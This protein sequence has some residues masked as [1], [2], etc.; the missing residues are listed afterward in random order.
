MDI[1]DYE[2]IVA[3][4]EQGSISRA[5]A[6][7]FITQSALTRFLQRTERDLGIALFLRKGNQFLLTEAGQQYVE[8]GRVIMHL[9]RELSEKLS[10][11]QRLQKSQISL[12]FSMG[13]TG[14]MLANVFPLFYEKY[15]DVQ[16]FVKADT[17]RRQMM[18]L[19]ND[20][21]D[22]A[23]VT[24]VEKLPGY[25]YVPVGRSW[26]ALAVREDSALVAESRE[27]DGYPYPV[28]ARER[29]E[30]M[31]FVTLPAITNSGNLAKELCSKY[32]IH[33]KRILELSDVR[34]LM[35]A[36]E[37]G[38]GAAMLMAVP[39]GRTKIR[40]LSIEGVE[41][42]EQMT[43]LVYKSDKNLSAA[44]KYLIQ[45]IADQQRRE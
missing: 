1:R 41:V 28:I 35:Y 15:P 2:Y 20:N 21:L 14:D 24:N 27:T 30:G 36:V 18:A 43:E 39:A 4:A 34:S 3:I 13:R 11:E 22:L 5:A 12:G 8:T 7:L 26:L 29:L 16:I 6:Q 25:H 17:S 32:G 40:Y 31:P 42:P 37:V 19:Q 45:V 44:M 38:L 23:M 33:P 9:D 10:R